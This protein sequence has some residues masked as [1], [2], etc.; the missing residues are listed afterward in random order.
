MANASIPVGGLAGT[1]RTPGPG[2]GGFSRTSLVRPYARMRLDQLAREDAALA[3]RR[4]LRR[5]VEKA[6]GTRFG[7]HHDF[8]GIRTVAD[9]GFL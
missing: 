5:L 7:K 1:A 2:R 4:T 8:A 9:H 3:Q 6:A